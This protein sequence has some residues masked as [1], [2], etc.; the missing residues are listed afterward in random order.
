VLSSGGSF[1][2]CTNV[3]SYDYLGIRTKIMNTKLNVLLSRPNIV[4]VIGS[5][6]DARVALNQPNLAYIYEW[7]VDRCPDQRTHEL[8]CELVQGH[9]KPLIVTVRAHDE[10]GKRI[11]AEE[12]RASLYSRYLSLATLIDVEV[13]SAS[14][15]SVLLREAREAEVGVILSQHFLKGPW[16]PSSLARGMQICQNSRADLYKVAFLPDSFSELCDFLSRIA[17]LLE[18]TSVP[19]AFMAMG[20]QFGRASRLFCARAGSVL[21]YGYLSKAVVKGQWHVKELRALLRKLD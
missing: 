3:A 16:V 5:N 4:G 20:T 8:V 2:I 11:W 17:W 9:N 6:A 21:N 13:S 12:K 1:F 15:L 19:I 10:G 7:R 14:R 18:N